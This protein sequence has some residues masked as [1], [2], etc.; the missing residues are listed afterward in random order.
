MAKKATAKRPKRAKKPASRAGTAVTRELDRVEKVLGALG[1]DFRVFSWRSAPPS[2][3]DIAAVEEEIDRPLPPDYRAFIARWGSLVI[4]VKP[5]IWPRPV[6]YEVRPSWQ[7]DFGRAVFGISREPAWMRVAERLEHLAG[8]G[9]P[10]GFLPVLQRL[11]GN[12]DVYGYDEDGSFCLY[13]HD[14]EETEPAD[15]FVETLLA[16]IESLRADR[17]RLRK[18]PV[19][20]PPAE[21]RDNRRRHVASFK[22]ELQLDAMLA[23]L[24]SLSREAAAAFPGLEVQ[25]RYDDQPWPIAE[26]LPDP[27]LA[28]SDDVFIELVYA[29]RGKIYDAFEIYLSP[30]FT[31]KPVRKVVGLSLLFRTVAPMATDPTAA[32]GLSLF[33]EALTREGVSFEQE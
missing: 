20:P 8:R 15:S 11:T 4:D 3:A 24:R 28:R 9:G 18:E 25:A 33:R 16:Q 21:E 27:F 29:R 2:E 30:S 26:P 19:A 1:D 5:E 12:G 32:R 23:A 22:A 31:F 14:T 10:D 13:T 17:E 6:Q 7:M